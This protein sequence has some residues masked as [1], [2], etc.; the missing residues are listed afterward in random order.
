MLFDRLESNH[1]LDSH[2]ANNE[3][4]RP[5][6]VE[7]ILKSDP[8]STHEYKTADSVRTQVYDAVAELLAEYDL[9]VAPSSAF[10]HSRTRSIRYLSKGQK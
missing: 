4:L 9:L 7:T 1:G 10:G 8:V 3:R 6:T 5:V 2:D